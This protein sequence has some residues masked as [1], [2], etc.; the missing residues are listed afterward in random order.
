MSFSLLTDKWHNTMTKMLQE[1]YI[2]IMSLFYTFLWDNHSSTI[3]YVKWVKHF[4]WISASNGTEDPRENI[5]KWP[6]T[7]FL[8]CQRFYCHYSDCSWFLLFPLKCFYPFQILSDVDRTKRWQLWLS[9]VCLP[10]ISFC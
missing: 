4:Q 1:A 3:F 9:Q 5:L 6:R 8:K 2:D 7:F 10:Q